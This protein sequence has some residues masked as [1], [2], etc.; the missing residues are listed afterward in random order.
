MNPRSMRTIRN[1]HV[2]IVDLICIILIGFGAY[3]IRFEHSYMYTK[4]TPVMMRMMAVSIIVKPIL[5]RHF[6]LYSRL[7]THAGIPEA[8]LILLAVTVASATVSAIMLIISRWFGQ[9]GVPRSIVVIDLLCSLFAV[10]GVRFMIRYIHDY[11][12]N[13]DGRRR[14]LRRKAVIIGA[15]DA[16]ILVLNEI[17]RNPQLGVTPVCFVDDDEKKRKLT[18]RSIRVEGT[19]LD[20]RRII[21]K[22]HITDCF[23]AI[24]SAPGSTVRAVSD[25]CRE[26][27]VTF[28]TMPGLYNILN[29]KVAVSAI[30]EV[31]IT[32]LLRRETVKLE[33]ENIEAILRNQTVLVT[34]GGGSIGREL[35]MQVAQYEPKEII[36]LGHGENSI[37]EAQ[38]DLKMR[39]AELNISAKIADIRDSSRINSIFAECKPDI[40]FH[41][42]AHK[43][44]PLMEENIIDAVTNNIFGTM[45]VVRLAKKHGVKRFVMIS[46]DKAV[47]PVNMMGASKRIAENIV[48]NESLDSDATFTAVRFGNVLGSRGSVVPTFKRQIANGGPV[49]ITHPDMERYFMTIPEAVYLVLESA[50]LAT[51]HETFVLNMGEQVKILSL[52]EDLI[53]LSGLEVG[54]DIE[55]RFTKMRPGEKLREDLWNKGQTLDPTIH[56][57]IFKLV[58]ADLLPP[59][60]METVLAKLEMLVKADDAE[61]VRAYLNEVIPDAELGSTE[62]SNGGQ[63][64]A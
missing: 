49:T 58:R 12:H 1:R 31:D 36:L 9:L 16:G 26:K 10:G 29:G 59:D 14:E 41:A 52:A 11:T 33:T 50:G 40:V 34:G 38:N 24:P 51:H 54:R 43:H 62:H 48:L 28:K 5:Y 17:L 47:R 61:G 32:D 19:T 4:Y 15:G 7:W 63:T 39:Y 27:H 30:R 60:E 3:L 13:Q 57:D 46:T 18:I 53:R 55:I 37:F 42:A 64:H 23:F 8:A 35:C 6:G 20:L 56:P 45:T 21:D 22:F 2:L 25:V 44:V